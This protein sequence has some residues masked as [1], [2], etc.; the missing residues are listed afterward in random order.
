MSALFPK[1]L[2]KTIDPDKP[3]GCGLNAKK[4]PKSPEGLTLKGGFWGAVSSS[5]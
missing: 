5:I 2:P 4:P 3:H 1:S